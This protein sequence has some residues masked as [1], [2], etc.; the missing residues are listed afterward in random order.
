M[1]PLFAIA[2]SSG[3]EDLRVCK[4]RQLGGD[5]CLSKAGVPSNV[6]RTPAQDRSSLL[7]SDSPSEVPVLIRPVT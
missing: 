4:S 7:T 1:I 6:N 3:A 2:L 5:H